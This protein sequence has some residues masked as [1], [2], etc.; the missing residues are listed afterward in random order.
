MDIIATPI[1]LLTRDYRENFT[2]TKIIVLGILIIEDHPGLASPK[3]YPPQNR[4]LRKRLNWHQLI[5]DLIDERT[6]QWKN[7]L[8]DQDMPTMPEDLPPLSGFSFNPFTEIYIVRIETHL[9]NMISE[10]LDS[11]LIIRS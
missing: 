9:S 3:P 4:P 11:L 5:T 7:F 1:L 6:I 8:L 2:P 10:F